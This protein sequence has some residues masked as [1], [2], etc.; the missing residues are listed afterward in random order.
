MKV[1]YISPFVESSMNVFETLMNMTPERGKLSARPQIFT[2]QQVNIVC[3]IAGDV[4]G[5]V[6]YGMSI[7]AADKI[8]SLGVKAGNMGGFDKWV[9]AGLPVKQ[10]E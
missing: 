5:Q 8:A 10:L 7:V 2:S 3:G 4:E 1:E 6:I 9:G